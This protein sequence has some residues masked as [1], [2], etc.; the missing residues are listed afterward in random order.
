MVEEEAEVEAVGQV[1]GQAVG[2]VVEEV[3]ALL[4]PKRHHQ[5]E[6]EVVGRLQS[7][8]VQ[9]RELAQEQVVLEAMR[10]PA[11]DLPVVL[12]DKECLGEFLRNRPCLALFD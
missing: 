9:A 11:G 12:V 1:V 10:G 8:K 4:L 7:L 6:E 3:L 5:E 2:Q